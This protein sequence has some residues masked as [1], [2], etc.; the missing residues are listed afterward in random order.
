MRSWFDRLPP[1][2]RS[3]PGQRWLNIAL[4]GLHLVGVAGM[5]GGFLFGLPDS[6]WQAYWHLAGVTGVLMS[7]IYLWI[8]Q[9]WIRQLKGQVIVLK[10]LLLWVGL[11]WPPAQ[12]SIF[13]LVILLSAL[14]AHAPASLRSYAWGREVRVCGSEPGG[15]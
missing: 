15:K 7:L 10:V 5:A 12:A 4:R 6:Q 11:A 3:F 8:D 14:F 2:P 9:E 13:I 1:P